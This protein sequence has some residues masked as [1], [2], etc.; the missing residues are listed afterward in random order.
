MIP[1]EVMRQAQQEFLDWNGMGVSVMEISHRSKEFK[2]IAEESKQDCRELLNISDDY[3]ILFLHGGARSQ[4]AMIPMNLMGDNKKAAYMQTGIWSE[5]AVKE[6]SRYCQPDI[7][8]HG[9]AT[10]YRS[11]PEPKAWGDFSNAAYLYYVDN[12]TVHGIEFPYV[13]DSG[14]VP[15]VCDMSSNIMSRLVDVSKFGLIFACAQKNLGQAGITLVIIRKD[16]LKR[17]KMPFTPSMFDYALQAEN[18]SML[19]TSPTYSW[20]ML[21]LVLKWLKKQ[22]GLTAMAERNNRKAKKLYDFIDQHDF[23]SNPVEKAFRSRMNVV[24]NLA[25]KTL[26]ERFLKEAKAAGMMGL[27]GH[28]YVGGMRASIYNAMPEEGVDMLID[29]MK[30]FSERAA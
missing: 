10:H 19:N 11:I 22:G 20:Y 6:A 29:F 26:E 15:L 21:G 4:F 14:D 1:V 24:F 8:V 7:V 23:Y 16:L 27:E 18:D 9:D 17:K 2:V 12:E 28:R 3:E 5:L 25:D 30:T 13:P